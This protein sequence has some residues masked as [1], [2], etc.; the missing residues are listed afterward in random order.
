MA[1]LREKDRRA[2]ARRVPT[3]Q[4]DNE[5]VSFFVMLRTHR[6]DD[7]FAIE[8]G[9]SLGG[10]SPLLFLARAPVPERALAYKGHRFRLVRLWEDSDKW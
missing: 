2:A 8:I 9:W 3:L 10:V 4:L 6:R 5:S 7:S 1:L